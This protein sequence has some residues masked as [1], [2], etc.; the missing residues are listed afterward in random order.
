MAFEFQAHRGVVI[1][2][3]GVVAA[4]QPLAVSAG[5]RVL[6]E[7]GNCVDAALAVSSVLCVIEPYNSHLG[8]DAF[9]IHYD[10]K[11]RR[12]TAYNGSGA[13]PATATLDR[14][15]NGIPIRGLEA[16]SVPGLVD[17]WY[18]L[19]D[20]HGTRPV[21]EL[22]RDAIAYAHDGFPAG[23]RYCRVFADAARTESAEWFTPMSRELTGLDHLP[24]PGETIRQPDLAQTLEQIALGGRDAFYEGEIAERL[25]AAMPRQGG[26]MSGQDLA[27]HSTDVKEPLRADYRGYA[28]HGQPPVSQGHILLQMLNLVETL[29][30][31]GGGP[32]GADAIHGLVEAKKLAFADRAAYLGD[33]AFV[34]V[35]LDMLL[36]KEYAAERRKQINPRCAATVVQAGQIPHDTTYFCAADREGNAVSFIQSIFHRFGCG[37]VAK[38]T[39]ILF[40]NRMTGFSL[41]PVSPNVLAPGKRTAHTLNAYVITRGDRLGWAGGTPGGDVQVQSNAQVIRHLI[42]FGAN[43]QQ[44]I[45]LPRWQHAWVPGD[46]DGGVLEIEDRMPANVVEELRSRGHRVRLIGPWAHGS[47]YQLIQVDPESGTY[48]AGSDPRADGHASGW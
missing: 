26:L 15:A 20:T 3:N 23:F 28:V 18:R 27:L 36:S 19:H 6:Q 8:G 34:D 13:A 4:S 31:N 41:D 33:P 17:A 43:P 30:V 45:E 16:A 10:A 48:F 44:A 12:T 5:M 40:N 39:G 24:R 11:T 25:D 38:G 47:T 14:F 9:V 1:A 32:L 46:P 29:D 22:L 21:E 42:E 7:G 37:V 2:R 35:P